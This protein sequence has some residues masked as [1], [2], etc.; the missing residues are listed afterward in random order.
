MPSS[1]ADRS[2]PELM[3]AMNY[4]LDNPM[5]VALAGFGTVGQSVA[6]HLMGDGIPA[7]RLTAISA[8]DLDKARQ[9]SA[10]LKP[11]PHVVPVANLPAHADVVVEC[12]PA[13]AFR[14]IAEPALMAGKTLVAVSPS[15]LAS[16]PDLIDLAQ[17]HGGRIQ[18]ATGALPGLDTVRGARENGIK[19][20]KLVA[21]F[22]PDRLARSDYVIAHGFN[23]STPPEAPVL[24]FSGTAREAT[25]TFPRHLNVAAALALA[26]TGLDETLVDLWVDP[27]SIGTTLR[28][29]LDSDVI[30]LDLAAWNQPSGGEKGGTSK[31]VAPSILAALRAMVSP[32]RV[33]S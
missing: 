7:I 8:R 5:R 24:I 32:L 6:R 27:D 15:A 18:I 4:S 1:S 3:P 30:K 12:A 29:E 14:E 2:E 13:A 21:H 28:I 33:G 19:S 9:A 22:R 23:F 20:V 31:I 10:R 25:T 26:G 11:A 16:Q 17:A